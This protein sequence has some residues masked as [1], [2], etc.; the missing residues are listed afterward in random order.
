[1]NLKNNILLLITLSLSLFCI[2]CQKQEK[3]KDIKDLQAYISQK[4]SSGEKHIVIPE[5]VYKVKTT[6]SAYLT[7]KDIKDVYISA[8]NVELRAICGRDIPS[9]R[10]MDLKNC[11][12]LTIDGLILDSDPIPFTQ[13]KITKLAKDNTWF[14]FT[15]SKGYATDIKGVSDIRYLQIYGKD[16]KLKCPLVRAKEIVK[17]SENTYR[18]LKADSYVK[19][20]PYRE[21]V[22][23]MFCASFN[24]GAT[25]VFV[26]DCKNVTFKDV[27]LYSSCGMA[28]YELRCDKTTYESCVITRRDTNDYVERETPRLRSSTADGYHSR[29]AKTGPQIINSIAEYSADDTVA[30]ECVYNLAVSS[31]PKERT[32]RLLMRDAKV[33]TIK[34]GDPVE[35]FTPDGKVERA[36]A[37]E[38]SYAGATTPEEIEIVKKLP[39]QTSFVK[40]MN[41]AISIKLDSGKTYPQGTL[42]T[43]LNSA[44]RGF[45]I[46]GGRFGNVRSRGLLLKASDG[47][48]DGA[49]I[50]DCW[51]SCVKM[52]P[53]HFWLEAPHSNN[54]VIKN[55]KIDGSFGIPIDIH[56]KQFDAK[57]LSKAGAH[58]NIAIENSEIIYSAD[59]SSQITS[60]DGLKITNNKIVSVKN[61]KTSATKSTSAPKQ[62]FVISNCANVD[63]STDKNKIEHR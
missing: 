54:V 21:D 51:M 29:Y 33:P 18:L 57:T 17:I 58:K 3:A 2:A 36:K 43:S 42:I 45:K 53:E 15:I 38:V 52:A 39:F 20:S 8:K 47:I 32:I 14:E 30:L 55:C 28:Y 41:H 24:Y 9:A 62:P 59:S 31:N 49:T 56:S 34:T 5:G 46:I 26:V 60:V 44:C 10:L 4:I 23:D 1:M 50:T 22:G 13:G 27:K 48:V 6:Q 25:G 61:P 7:F 63:F 11:E 37:V 35:I 19:N 40:R 16:R 12:N